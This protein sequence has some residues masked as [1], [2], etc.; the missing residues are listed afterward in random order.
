MKRTNEREKK[1][2]NS[3]KLM[4]ML[5]TF[6]KHTCILTGIEKLSFEKQK[7]KFRRGKKKQ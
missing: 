6:A 5:F 2:I 4:E 1:R 3:F 7:S